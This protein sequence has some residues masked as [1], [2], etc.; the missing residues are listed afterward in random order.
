M[1]FIKGMDI[2]MMNEMENLGAKYY[3]KGVEKD[4][5]TILKDYDVN[6]VRLRLW[7]NPYDDMGNPY[8]GG[9][10]DLEVTKK[11]SRRVIDAGLDFLLDIHYSDFWTDPGKQLKP[12]AWRNLSGDEL[13]KKVYTYTKHVLEE[14][15]KAGVKPSMVQVG[16]ELSNGILWPDGKLPDYQMMCSLIQNGIRAVREFDSSIRI[17]L[18]L[19]FGGNNNLYRTW[20]DKAKEYGL[21]FDIIGLSYYPYWHGTLDDL[22]NNMNDI[23]KRY[24]KDVMVVETAIGFTTDTCK[25]CSMIF[26]DELSAKV[27]Y[28]AS[29]DGQAEYLSA[30]MNLI[31]NI[32]NDRGLGFFYWEPA[33]IPVKGSTWET[34]SGRDYIGD[35]SEGGNTWANQ[36]LFDFKGNALKAL[37]TIKEFK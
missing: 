20:F 9:T 28:E 8:G 1:K 13:K 35:N 34:K 32:D 16:N 7:D 25:E 10:N 14:L 27:K 21:D 3:D 30:L 24:D 5:L 11:L 6:A 36:S 37:N 4:L 33:W 29:E 2:S 12:K 18:H 15:D 22:R 31:K 23:S 26:S 17:I 19:D